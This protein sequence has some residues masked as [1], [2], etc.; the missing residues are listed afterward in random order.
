[1]TRSLALAL[2]T[3]GAASIASASDAPAF[4]QPSFVDYVVAE[5]PDASASAGGS[6]M[7]A[8]MVKEE[9]SQ[10]LP[11]PSFLDTGTPT[12]DEWNR[13]NR[14]AIEVTESSAQ[15]SPAPSFLN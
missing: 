12:W 5:A 6:V 10:P 1:M 8:A 13:R 4:P 11:A 15:R 7:D 9:R 14:D 2:C 3:F